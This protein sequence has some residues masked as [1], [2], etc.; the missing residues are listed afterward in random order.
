MI[1]TL[2]SKTIFKNIMYITVSAF[3]MLLVMAIMSSLHY[4]KTVTVNELDVDLVRGSAVLQAP[5]DN[6]LPI[7]IDGEWNRYENLYF[8]DD[9]IDYSLLKE[10]EFVKFP[11]SIIT[12]ARGTSTYQG[13]IKFDINEWDTQYDDDKVVLALPKTE[14]PINVYINGFAVPEYTPLN[15]SVGILATTQMYDLELYYNSS[16][17]YQEIIISV[18]EDPSQALLYNKSLSIGTYA[19]ILGIE[20]VTLALH[21]MFLGVMICMILFGMAYIASLPTY[22]TLT[23][24]N[25]FDTALMLHIIFSLGVIPRIMQNNFIYGEINEMTILGLDLFFLMIAAALGNTLSGLLF[26][27][28]QEIPK[29]FGKPVMFA[30][31]AL[32]VIFGLYPEVYANGGIFIYMA[33][34]LVTFVGIILRY[35]NMRKKQRV[36]LYIKL[37]FVKT[38]FLGV[39]VAFDVLNFGKDSLLQLLVFTGFV[40]F[41][42]LHIIVRA[43][44]FRLPYLEIE[45]INTGLEEEIERRTA[46]LKEANVVLRNLNERDALTKS[47]N[48]LYFEEELANA[49]DKFK[50]SELQ[51]LHLVLFDLDSFKQIND[52]YGHGEGDEQLIETVKRTNDISPD[53]V[54]VCRI[55]GE[56]FTLMFTNYSL[57]DV[58]DYV[59]K[60]RA[61]FEELMNSNKARTTGSF[62]IASA[63]LCI[64]KKDLI[65][66]ADKCLYHSKET[67]KN[68]ITYQTRGGMVTYNKSE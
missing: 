13:F 1:E 39:V 65:L 47:Y 38:V 61:S 57:E 32:A 21:F 60:I 54:P 40:T 29:I 28:E 37:H 52:I 9:V 41:L 5:S 43:Y 10:S 62:G 15:S 27:P 33:M 49:V 30:Y 6:R 35:L 36:T 2:K 63:D 12:L 18:N 59:E 58:I 64:N 17:E 20:T 50:V 25:L 66:Q 55:G 46:E 22:S 3:V 45:S 23:F 7:T 56:E 11:I 24:I 68:R 42:G 44:E 14:Q 16:R 67:G 26:D 53:S 8:T 4:L 34:L 19:N 31:L 51:S 48:R